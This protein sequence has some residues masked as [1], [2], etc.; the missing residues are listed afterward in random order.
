M[1]PPGLQAGPAPPNDDSPKQRFLESNYIIRQVASGSFATVYLSI[2]K[3]TADHL[4]SDPTLSPDK[5]HSSLRQAIQAAKISKSPT[6]D[7]TSEM[8]ILK[9]IAEVSKPSPSFTLP[10]LISSDPSA[11]PTWFTT[12][13]LNGGT[14]TD[15]IREY[16][17]PSST[18]PPLPPS[19]L[20]HCI[21]Q[22]AHSLL[23]LHQGLTILRSPQGTPKRHSHDLWIP[24]IHKDIH[25]QNL[26]FHTPSE[27]SYPDLILSDFGISILQSDP[28]AQDVAWTNLKEKQI[29]DM[30][31]TL[32][33]LAN[34]IEGNGDGDEFLEILFD[35]T[36]NFRRRGDEDAEDD[37]EREFLEKV[38]GLAE[39]RKKELWKPM[40]R[41]LRE[42]FGGGKGVED[43][44]LEE[45]VRGLRAGR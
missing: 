24:I 19:L 42:Y 44:E 45:F 3:S 29:S 23:F 27:D 10:H 16:Q 30:L 5:L 7:M 36:P 38:I 4:I 18:L 15:L 9:A 6:L 28:S 8:R 33:Q 13:Y 20:W 41:G 39:K 32:E 2:P 35:Q 21:S 34:K 40:P 25:P 12:P 31:C 22:M 43:G 17:K 37:A 1:L 14:L 11:P 26:I